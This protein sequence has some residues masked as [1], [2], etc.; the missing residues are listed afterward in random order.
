MIEIEKNVKEI[1]LCISTVSETKL[2][3][4]CAHTHTYKHRH[5]CSQFSLTTVYLE[6][7]Q[8]AGE[9]KSFFRPARLLSEFQWG[10]YRPHL[11]FY[12][13][14]CAYYFLTFFHHLFS[15][16]LCLFPYDVPLFSFMSCPNV[17]TPFFPLIF[18]HCILF[19]LVSHP[20]LTPFLSFRRL[21]TTLWCL[22]KLG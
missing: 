1:N 11:S 8:T 22:S 19:S 20:A 6:K 17:C 2:K 3:C 16:S 4:M 15:P 13:S 5:A 14:S 21:L 12:I 18:S 7:L 9:F 10:H